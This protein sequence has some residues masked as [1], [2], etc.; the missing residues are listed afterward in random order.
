MRKG[1]SMSVYRSGTPRLLM[2]WEAALRLER[3]PEQGSPRL[4][5]ARVDAHD[6]NSRWRIALRGCDMNTMSSSFAFGHDPPRGD[7]GNT[8]EGVGAKSSPRPSPAVW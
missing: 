6:R 1:R 7:V 2:L 3:S 8:R 4:P 5:Q